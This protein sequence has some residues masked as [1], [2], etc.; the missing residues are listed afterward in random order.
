LR[1]KSC[2]DNLWWIEHKLYN[3]N[4]AFNLSGVL[5]EE[6][7]EILTDIFR[8]Y[9]PIYDET[10]HK[11]ILDLHIEI[12]TKQDNWK[13]YLSL[14]EQYLEKVSTL[15]QFDAVPNNIELSEDSLI[16]YEAKRK[17]FESTR[18]DNHEFDT[19]DAEMCFEWLVDPKNVRQDVPFELMLMMRKRS[20]FRTRFNR[21]FNKI[22][23]PII[24][25]D[26]VAK[27]M[28]ASGMGPKGFDIE[29]HY[30][31][32][33]TALYNNP[34]KITDL[35]SPRFDSAS[36][37]PFHILFYNLLFNKF[38]WWFDR[39]NERGLVVQWQEIGTKDVKMPHLILLDKNFENR[40]AEQNRQDKLLEERV[41]EME[42][43]HFKDMSIDEAMKWVKEINP[44]NDDIEII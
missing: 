2:M 12:A 3:M 7:R 24:K 20:H 29:K 38:K 13:L 42:V 16:L 6:N 41:A 9:K 30:R 18:T 35:P 14:K 25:D 28:A 5:D 44:I 8:D 19:N 10:D 31:K 17:K 26:W 36:G 39:K 37:K 34:V 22:H 23:A 32:L 15:L 43:D 21:W 33:E 4:F 40:L 11:Y 1:A 27:Q